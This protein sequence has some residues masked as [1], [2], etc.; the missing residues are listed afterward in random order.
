MRRLNSIKTPKNRLEY[1]DQLEE[2]S[3]YLFQDIAITE[4]ARDNPKLGKLLLQLRDWHTNNPHEKLHWAGYRFAEELKEIHNGDA[5]SAFKELAY[6]RDEEKIKKFA[7]M[8]KPHNASYNE[9]WMITNTQAQ[10]IKRMKSQTDKKISSV[11]SQL[12]KIVNLDESIRG[13]WID[14]IKEYQKR[15]AGLYVGYVNYLY[16]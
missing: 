15:V 16:K 3:A 4:Y 6:L 12:K 7:E 1:L 9:F 2:A 14:K 11:S 8:L 13:I 10:Q 5:L